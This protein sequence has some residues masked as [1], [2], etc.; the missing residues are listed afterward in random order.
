MFEMGCYC[1]VKGEDVFDIAF[2]DHLCFQP[3]YTVSSVNM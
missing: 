1:Y 3:L 2:Y